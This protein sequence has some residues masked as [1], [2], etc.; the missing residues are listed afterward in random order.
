MKSR[1]KNSV[2]I[3]KMQIL[4]VVEET[5]NLE[6]ACG[7]SLGPIDVAY[8]TYG[9]LNKEADNAVLVCHALSGDAHAAGYHSS[10]DTK[11]GWWDSMIGPGKGIDTDKYFV[12]CSNFLGGCAGTTGPGSVNPKTNKPYGLDFPIITVSDMVKVQKLLVEKL[13]VKKLLSVIGGSMGG[14]QV[15]QWAV[16]YGDMVQSVIPIATTTRLAAQSLAFDAVGRSAIL[17]DPD[18]CGGDYTGEKSPDQGLAIARMIGH[19]TYLS[20]AGMHAKFGRDLRIAKDY[21]YDF[22]SEFSVETYL[23]YQ[24]QRFVE[25]FDANSY[26]YISKAMDYF[27]LQKDYGSLTNAFRK[28]SSRFLVISFTSDWLFSPAQSEAIVNALKACSKEVSFCNI[29]SHFGHD[30]F[31]LETTTLAEFISS[32]L[33]STF[34]TPSEKQIRAEA[35]IITKRAHDRYE[36]AKRTRIDYQLISSLIKP[37]STVL[38]IGCGDG[39]LLSN[40]KADKNVTGVGIELNQDL[41]LACVSRRLNA[42]QYDI[43]RGLDHIAD[44]SFDYVILSQTV[45]TLKNPK[46]ILKE[47]LRV[48]KRLIVSFPNFANWNCRLQL[49]LLGQAPV[50]GGLPFGWYNSPNIHFLSIKDFDAFCDR[51]GA[52]VEH[53]IMLAK[54]RRWPQWLLPNV[55]AEQ[56]IYV[57]RKIK[58]KENKKLEG[59]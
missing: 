45:Q 23:D 25:R 38:D 50:T 3:V 13:G 48:G 14:M 55:F 51:I 39:K 26:L 57:T 54:S 53:K 59:K 17:A 47:L 2:G 34:K 42:V 19:I 9:K 27:D 36:E 28:T 24:G 44:D 1:L 5:E 58:T 52:S 37:G 30:S 43:E 20:E 32:F 33:E 40:L 16:D 12:I 11:A 6:L 10:D 22:A 49:S 41:I 7:K 8:E 35:A 15:L 56:A 4:R 46:K 18:F 31:L 29:D 21:N